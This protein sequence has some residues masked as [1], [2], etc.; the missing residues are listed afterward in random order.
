MLSLVGGHE[1]WVW[2]CRA[3]PGSSQNF[4]VNSLIFSML[5]GNHACAHIH[6]DTL[7]L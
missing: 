2:C 6:M 3:R 5:L 4:V 1:S 7:Y